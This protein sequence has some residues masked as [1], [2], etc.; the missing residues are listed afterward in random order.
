M[1]RCSTHHIDVELDRHGH[2]S[3]WKAGPTVGPFVSDL[4]ARDFTLLQGAGWR[5]VGL[6]FGASFAYAPPA[7]WRAMR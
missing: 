2:P 1:S 5:P 6:A 4:S 7:G 3:S